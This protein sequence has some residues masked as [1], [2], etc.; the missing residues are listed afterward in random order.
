MMMGHHFM[1]GVPF[2]TVYIH[3]LVRDEKGQKMSKSKGNVIDPLDLIATYGTDALRFTVC[4]LTGPGRD[5]KLGQARVE[6]Y[7]SFVTKLWNA[8]R[9]A[10]MNGVVPVPGF[11]PQG[12]Q[13]PLCRWV[14]DAANTAV[15]EATAALEAYRFNDYAAA[16][17]R[18]TWNTYC[19]WFLEFAKPVLNGP[20]G[21]AKD[22]VRATAAHVLG[23]ILRLL[24]P[25]MPFVT[26]HL[27]D[28]MGFGAPCTLIRAEWPGAMT[29]HAA[30]AARGEM[31]WLVRFISALRTVRS[32]MNVAPSVLTPVLLQGAAP[33]TVARA[34]AWG[35]A[36]AR[37]GRASS[38]A[39]LDGAMPDGSAQ[40]VV[41][42]ATVVLP[43]AGIIDLAAERARLEKDRAKAEAEAEKV[44]RKLENAD[45]VARAKP[46]VVEENRERLAASEAEVA[47]LIQAVGRLLT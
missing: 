44:R 7:R 45:F 12:A 15:A 30:E 39:P 4:A 26:E 27:W 17:Y 36:V 25:A 41:D 6:S 9:F 2:H 35:E 24:H 31:D 18:F 16:A 22:E 37:M 43:L 38:V 28:K 21:G 1:G 3:G 34:A 20:D 42:E 29:V 13:S 47:R 5:V 23:V 40:V 33:E 10:E 14:L 19:D 46:E 32:E 11:E 8:A